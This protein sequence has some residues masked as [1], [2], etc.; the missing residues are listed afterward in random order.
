M[1]ERLDVATLCL[2]AFRRAAVRQGGGWR[3]RYVALL[4]GVQ[5]CVERVHGVRLDERGLLL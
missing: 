5:A 3:R 4:G 2:R 1:N